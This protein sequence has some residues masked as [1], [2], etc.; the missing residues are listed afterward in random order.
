MRGSGGMEDIEVS[1]W[2]KRNNETLHQIQSSHT[3]TVV[4]KDMHWEFLH[5]Q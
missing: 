1:V 5:N 4:G 2:T 3:P